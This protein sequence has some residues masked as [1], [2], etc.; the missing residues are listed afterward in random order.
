M[1]M[2]KRIQLIHRLQKKYER[3]SVRN[4]I[5]IAVFLV[6]MTVVV[7]SAGFFFT[8]YT[9]V[10]EED[11]RRQFSE[12]C[13]QAAVSLNYMCSSVEDNGKYILNSTELLR[14]FQHLS[15]ENYTLSQELDDFFSISQVTVRYNVS[16]AVKS[17]RYYFNTDA[18]YTRERESIFPL[19][20]ISK[21]PWY[22]RMLIA[23][24]APFWV[25][26]PESGRVSCFQAVYQNIQTGELLGVLEQELDKE[27]VLQIMNSVSSFSMDQTVL[28]DHQGE[29]AYYVGSGSENV[30][31]EYSG[32]LPSGEKMELYSG[33][34]EIYAG[35]RLNNQF[36]LLGRLP[37]SHIKDQM[38]T[39]VA[40]ML[41]FC[42]VAMIIAAMLAGIISNS[43]SGRIQRIVEKVGRIKIDSKEYLPVKYDDEITKIE[44]MF[45]R[46]LKTIRTYIAE[47]N[48]VQQQKKEAD[49]RVLQEQIN[50]HFLYNCLDS[51]NWMA[52]DRGE[53]QI[54]QMSQL[55]G[56]FFRLSL[57]KGSQII[58]F[59]DE[60]EHVKI[61]LSI[62][63][64]R[65][66]NAISV[67]YEVDPSSYSL[68]ILKIL[69][70]PLVE[71]AILHGINGQS[72][73]TG[74]I[75]ITAK[76][77][78][79]ALSVSVRDDGVGIPR[80]ALQTIQS[81]LDSSEAPQRC[82]A[83]WNMNQRLML[84]YGKEHR[85]TVESRE[86]AGTTVSFEIPYRMTM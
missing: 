41:A 42:L 78:A 81:I 5:L 72:S 4:K 50:P 76:T 45:N 3:T 86:F 22:E 38:G 57:S 27:S 28:L 25:Y 62:M 77:S 35:C 83:L 58:P 26:L 10:I 63:Q 39:P 55:L 12:F 70:Q 73:Q 74:T 65:F 32:P 7:G 40:E 85:L 23:K 71:N 51:I 24:G 29:M 13:V 75:W 21:E 79:A 34:D 68:P 37:N 14:V 56:R 9:K 47:N 84:H 20:K 6:V 16:R 18:I 1:T 36:I 19:D 66:E 60:L 46:F 61:Y 67:H 52:L 30:P 64:V 49:F 31:V 48:Q 8:R 82:F 80:E 17:I 54:A 44:L 15:Q 69:L 11:S 33:R 43:L 2:R 53:R 59:A